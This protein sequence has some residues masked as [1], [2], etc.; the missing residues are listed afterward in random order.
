M[1]SGVHRRSGAVLAAFALAL[2]PGWAAP[3]VLSVEDAYKTPG[4]LQARLSPDGQHVAA[5]VFNGYNRSVMLVKT[6]DLS[7]RIIVLGQ[8]GADG[9]YRV[10]R[11]A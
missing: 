9:F 3:S 4:V 6:A 11:N 8:W 10:N 2:G 7:S 1:R 5:I